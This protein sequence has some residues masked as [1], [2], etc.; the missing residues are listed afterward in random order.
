MGQWVQAPLPGP[1]AT[2]APAAG[3]CSISVGAGLL[4]S[5]IL[6]YILKNFYFYFYVIVPDCNLG[7]VL[8]RMVRNKPDV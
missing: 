6:Y 2:D 3:S 8:V 1:E 7:L 4:L 5:P